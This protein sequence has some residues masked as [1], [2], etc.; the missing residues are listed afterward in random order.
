L[1]EWGDFRE[2]M[3]AK[4]TR[5]IFGCS[6]SFFVVTAELAKVDD[7]FVRLATDGH[8]VH[9]PAVMSAGQRV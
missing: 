2:T 4:E 8:C 5:R 7:P 3:R 6:I 9:K 1:E